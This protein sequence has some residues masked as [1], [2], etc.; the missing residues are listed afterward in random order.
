M[1]QPPGCPKRRGHLNNNLS[2]N[3]IRL[4]GVPET[5]EDARQLADADKFEFEKWA[6]GHVGA[7]GMFHD[8]GTRG[9]DGG[10]DGVLKFYP[11]EEPLKAQYAIIQVKG[12]GVSSDSVRALESTVRRFDAKA[13]IMICFE[14]QM[15]TVENNRS[16]ETFTDGTSLM[17]RRDFPVIQG[18]SVE[19]MLLRGR[20]PNLPNIMKMV[21][22]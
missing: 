1:A 15:R 6:C 10:I 19:D 9:A 21:K 13:G 11:L 18:L 14:D 3:D 4:F 20:Q 2:P 8:P 22:A 7:E 17:E 12:G 16:K 5:P